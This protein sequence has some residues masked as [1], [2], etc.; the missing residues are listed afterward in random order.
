MVLRSFEHPIQ[1]G[2]SFG[3]AS[4]VITSLGLVVGL[5]S[6]TESRIAVIGGIVTIAIADSLSDALG[7]HISEEAERV[8]TSM[9][10]WLATG[11]T[12]V[13]KLVVASSFLVPVLLLELAN[14]VWVSVAWGIAAVTALSWY[15]AREQAA[16]RMLV[17]AEHVGVAVLV[18][19]ASALVGRWVSTTFG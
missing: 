8:H 5:A 14:A 7:I 13:T 17:V 15:V 2:M 19:I 6:G 10:I 11:A 1:V 16:S 18:V 3:L 9:E 4:G 12:F